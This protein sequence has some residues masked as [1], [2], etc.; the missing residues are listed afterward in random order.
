MIVRWVSRHRA[1][2]LT[3][4]YT[5]GFGESGV[6]ST[7]TERPVSPQRLPFAKLPLLVGQEREQVLLHDRTSQTQER[8]K[9][10]RGNLPIPKDQ[11]TVQAR[12]TDRIRSEVQGKGQG[13]RTLQRVVAKRIAAPRR[14]AI[15]RIITYPVQTRS[16]GI[17]V[18]ILTL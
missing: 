2:S 3:N 15:T 17:V 12:Q 13:I 8:L 1:R 16:R 14:T 4:E 6:Q 7:D 10:C 5:N 18:L 11:E 9:V